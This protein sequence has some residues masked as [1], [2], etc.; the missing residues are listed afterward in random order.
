VAVDA[1]PSPAR[2]AGR[3]EVSTLG[4]WMAV[5]VAVV[6]GKFSEWVPGLA[7]VPLAKIVIVITAVLA[8][9]ARDSLLPVRL[10]SL[11][12]APP[13]LAFLGLALISF[14]FSVYKSETLSE[15]YG[16]AVCLLSFVVLVKITQSARDVRRLLWALCLAAGALALAVVFT[17]SSGR[18]RINENFDPNDLAY[19]LVTLLPVMRALAATVKRGAIFL[20]GL[21]IAAVIA[22]L[23]TGSRGGAIGL[24]MVALLLVAFPLSFNK[25]GELKGFRIGRLIAAVCLITAIGVALW[26][27]LPADSRA[28]LSTLGDLQNDYNVGDPRGGRLAIWTRD[29][30]AVW[31]RPIGYGLGSFGYVDGKM[32]GSYRAPHNSFLE[33][34]VELGVLGLILFCATYVIT[35]RQLGRV[36]GMGRRAAPEGDRAALCL[37]ARALRIG[38][39]G[40]IVC[41]FFLSQA[42]APL[43]WVLVAVCVALVRVSLPLAVPE[44]ASRRT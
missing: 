3:A 44:N 35:I 4:V 12:G 18:A 7:N 14:V 29:S 30:A 19:G 6:V 23:L 43:L 41:G 26:S 24:G 8:W 39:I 34:L 42:Y 10:W 11:R 15:S 38:L 21:T 32:G 17:Y 31:R 9:R 22:I 28:Q 1:L 25:S 2:A 16:I 27:H 20:H 37:Y 5:Y 13:A 36:S 40:N 33:A